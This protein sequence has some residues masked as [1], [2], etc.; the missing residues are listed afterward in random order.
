MA[1]ARQAALPALQA[2][3]QPG[4]SLNTRVQAIAQAAS[5]ADLLGAAIAERSELAR[6]AAQ[7]FERIE[8]I[9][10]CLHA[11]LSEVRAA[12]RLQWAEAFSQFDAARGTLDLGDLGLLPR[13]GDLPRE[14]REDIREL[15]A[16]LRRR[17]DAAEPR[18]V[19][20][21]ADLLRVC[22]GRQPFSVGEIVTGRIRGRC[23]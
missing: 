7:E 23:R 19:A 2:A 20:L 10:G 14:L 9:A 12:I 21:M 17:V 15:A 16:W 4:V 22:A 6:R 18:A 13:F 3:M 5:V 8:A 11:R 1:E